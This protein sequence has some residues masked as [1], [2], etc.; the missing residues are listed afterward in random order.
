MRPPIHNPTKPHCFLTQR[1]SNPEASRTNEPEET[2]CTWQPWLACTAPGPTTLCQLCVAPRTSRSRPV[3]TE[4]GREPRVSGG[5]ALNHCATREAGK[6]VIEGDI[7]EFVC[8]VVIPP[9]N[10]TVFLT[11][12]K[13]MLKTAYISLSHSLRVLAEDSGEYVCKA[14]RGNVQKEA[15]ESIKV[16]G[17][18][19]PSQ[20]W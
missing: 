6:D 9:P 13:R 4:P 18:C 20:S 2:P 12:A 1:T 8:R 5:T 14:D 15:Y 10:V 3:T 7:V 19:F 16:K 11:K 17:N